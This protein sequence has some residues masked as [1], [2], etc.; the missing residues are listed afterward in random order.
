MAEYGGRICGEAR[1]RPPG[2]L[3]NRQGVESLRHNEVNRVFNDKYRVIQFLRF[4]TVGLGNTAVDFSVFF[5]LNMGGLPY[6][7]AQVLSYSAGVANSYFLNRKWTFRMARKA[8]VTEAA[9]F[10][11]VNLL[12]LLVT[13]GL[14]AI[15]HEVNNLDLWLCKIVATG[16]GVVV[17]FLGNRLW[18]FAENQKAGGEVS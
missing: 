11:I 9:H 17:N 1:N 8:S 5:L 2:I 12:S 3:R 13:A 7:P 4:C 15:L 10:I 16:A 6:L 18:V 14:L